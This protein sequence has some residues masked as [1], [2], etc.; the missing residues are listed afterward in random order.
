M[1]RR[2]AVCGEPLCLFLFGPDLVVHDRRPRLDCGHHSPPRLL[3]VSAACQGR[4]RRPR[5]QRG[6]QSGRRA[7]RHACDNRGCRPGARGMRRVHQMR[8]SAP[9][10]GPA[11]A[12]SGGAQ[13]PFR[14][15]RTEGEGIALVVGS[16]DEGC[17][18]ETPVPELRPWCEV[19]WIFRNGE[20]SPSSVRASHSAH[21]RTRIPPARDEYSDRLLGLGRL[22]STSGAWCVV[23]QVSQRERVR[24][25]MTTPPT[26]RRTPAIWTRS[27]P[28][29]PS[30]PNQ[31]CSSSERSIPQSTMRRTEH[32]AGGVAGAGQA[33]GPA[34]ERPFDEDQDHVD[35][36][37]LER[38]EDG[39]GEAPPALPGVVHAEPLVGGMPTAGHHELGSEQSAHG[40]AGHEHRA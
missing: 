36:E 14:G 40:P 35:A 23:S 16:A 15:G 8:P 33:V 2:V 24:R 7:E 30:S 6:L 39:H 34:V 28:S 22:G 1:G 9:S 18:S 12:L 11:A 20:R 32:D 5:L 37:V 4:L 17:E 29:A 25:K 26:T 27:E 38:L 21:A 3:S 19:G 13:T 31:R 10:P